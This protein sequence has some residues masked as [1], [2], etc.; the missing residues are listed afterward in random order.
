MRGPRPGRRQASDAARQAGSSST[1]NC[2][3]R[4]KP[5]SCTMA[6]QPI[7]RFVTSASGEPRAGATSQKS[8]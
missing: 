3:F 5:V 8:R 4:L 2:A 7:A 1:T 6:Q